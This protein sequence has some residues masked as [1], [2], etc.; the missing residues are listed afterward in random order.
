MT[1]FN[2][3]VLLMGIIGKDALAAHTIAIQIAS[4]VFMVPLGFGRR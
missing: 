1:I 2:A 4:L 3:A